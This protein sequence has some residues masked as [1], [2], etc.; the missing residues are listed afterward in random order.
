MVGPHYSSFDC[1]VRRPWE[2]VSL[3]SLLIGAILILVAI[4]VAI[5]GRFRTSLSIAVSGI[6]LIA[7]GVIVVVTAVANDFHLCA[8]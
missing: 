6:L 8:T 5:R 4:V 7:A 3:G 2:V 1:D